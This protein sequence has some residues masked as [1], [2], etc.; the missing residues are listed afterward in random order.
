M[1]SERDR[2]KCTYCLVDVAEDSYVLDHIVPVSKGGTNKK[3]NL[4]TYV[5]DVTRESK[6]K[7]LLSSS[8]QIIVPNLSVKMSN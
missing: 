5:K 7:M 2:H 6:M 4:V 3:F 1:V 8:Q